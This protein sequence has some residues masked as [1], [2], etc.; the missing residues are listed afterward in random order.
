M[1]IRYL[2][3]ASVCLAATARAQDAGAATAT[4]DELSLGGPAWSFGASVY[5]YLVPGEDFL[6]PTITADRDWLHL[7]A[8]Y[9]YEDIDTGSL[10]VGWNL[11]FGDE[12]S[13]EFTPMLG[14]VF[15]ATEGVA[16]GYKGSVSWWQLEFYS[17]GELLYDT[18][19]SSDS[20][21]YNWS[22][23]TVAVTDWLQVGVSVQ[24][25]R[26]YETD[27]DIQRGFVVG[28]TLGDFDLRAYVFNPDESKPVVI[29]GAGLTF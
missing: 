5:S 11:T 14:G 12:V 8:R 24:R 26:A 23:L 9:N 3:F 4:P 7:E 15:G 22:E 6:Q 18:E 17:E 27:L 1:D 10:W 21:F 29:L 13:V 19:R 2:L 28:T 25:T 20:Y 16:L